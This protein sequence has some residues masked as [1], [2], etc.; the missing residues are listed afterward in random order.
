MKKFAFLFATALFL[1]SCS[2]QGAFTEEEKKTQDSIDK[3][4]QEPQ[5]EEL[6]ALDIENDSNKSESQSESEV[7][8][9]GE[10]NQPAQSPKKQLE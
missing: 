10:E 3:S 6:E 8:K 9:D 2:N 7:P 5:F 1:F 4:S